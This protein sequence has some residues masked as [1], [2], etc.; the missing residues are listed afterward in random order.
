VSAA[1]DDSAGLLDASAALR[2]VAAG[3]ALAGRRAAGAR[4]LRVGEDALVRLADGVSARVGPV[5]GA[6]VA[7]HEIAVSRWLAAAGVPAVRP[8]AGTAAVDVG[9]RV[10]T[11][12]AALPA[13]RPAG[14]ELVALALRRLHS[15][16]VP[17]T[18][19]LPPLDPFRRIEPRLRRSAVVTPAQRG[20]LLARLDRLREAFGRLPPGRPP[21]VVHGDAWAGNVVETDRGEVVLLDLVRVGLGPPEWDLVATALD[22]STFGIMDDAGYDG[23]SAAYGLDVM[24]WPGFGV[25]RDIR[26]LRVAAYALHA[27]EVDPTLARLA[28]LR[29]RDLLAGVRPWPNW[30]PL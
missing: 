7:H 2:I 25:L 15:Q 16:P 9:A 30:S 21:C 22:R 23:F 28:S 19:A 17:T 8:A 11:F 3:C 18:P 1:S 27:A 4:P 14:S 6:W 10:V 26:E 29:V 13:H 24:A 20:E 5:G 12:W